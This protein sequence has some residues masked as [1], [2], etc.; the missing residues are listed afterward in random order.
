M[1]LVPIV[2]LNI[3]YGHAVSGMIFLFYKAFISQNTKLA[4]S[5]ISLHIFPK[6]L[7]FLHSVRTNFDDVLLR[8]PDFQTYKLFTIYSF[9]ARRGEGG[10]YKKSITF[11]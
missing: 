4:I 5:T 2:L 11:N 6:V 9:F 8:K 7:S 3:T 10:G 1:I